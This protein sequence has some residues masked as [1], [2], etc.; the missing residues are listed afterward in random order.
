MVDKKKI[1]LTYVPVGRAELA[2]RYQELMELRDTIKTA[3][4][5]ITIKRSDYFDL[6]YQYLA[7][8]V[9][10]NNMNVI[11]DIELLEED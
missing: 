1:E 7:A 4:E 11:Q 6:L 9:M 5:T 8:H 3:K 10:I 2:E